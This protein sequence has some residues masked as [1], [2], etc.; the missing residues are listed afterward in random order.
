[1]DKAIIRKQIRSQKKLLNKEMIEAASA[2]VCS[3]VLKLEEYKKADTIYVYIETNQE[4]CTKE[5]ILD[6]LKNGKKV[7]APKCFG[8]QMEFFYFKDVSELKEGT[9]GILEPSDENIAEAKEVFMLVPGMAFDRHNNRIGY[10]GGFYDRYFDSHSD[11][12]IYKCGLCHGFQLIDYIETEEHDKGVDI[13][14][15]S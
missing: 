11:L 7:A 9:Y 13:V 15:H 8:K 12:K 1:M 14:V 5:I 3:K 4:I 2:E 6:A 10:G